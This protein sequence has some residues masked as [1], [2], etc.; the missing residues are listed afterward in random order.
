MKKTGYFSFS[1]ADRI[2][3]RPNF[4]QLS[5]FGINIQNKDF[6]AVFKKNSSAR[7]RI[8]ITVTKRVGNAVTRN[9]L[10]R[11]VREYFRLHKHDL[12]RGLDINIITK[13]RAAQQTTTEIHASLQDIFNRISRRYV[14]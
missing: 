4:V 13:R 3:N 11:L 9:R 12:T 7:T 14:D 10:K 1:K 6:I 2:L 8:G 5:N